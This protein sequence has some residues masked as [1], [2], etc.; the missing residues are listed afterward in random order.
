MIK[1]TLKTIS[2]AS[3]SFSHFSKYLASRETCI[4]TRR[5]RGK[6][7]FVTS[8]KNSRPINSSV[9]IGVKFTY[10]FGRDDIQLSWPVQRDQPNMSDFFSQNNLKVDFNKHLVNER[11]RNFHK[12]YAWGNHFQSQARKMVKQKNYNE[13]KGSIRRSRRCSQELPLHPG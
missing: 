8:F 1:L 2:F 7:V 6:S 4:H 10:H 12:T 3:S 5:E 9:K 11:V 13:T